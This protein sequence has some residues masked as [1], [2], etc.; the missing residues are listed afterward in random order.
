MVF[1]QMSNGRGALPNNWGLQWMTVDYR[2]LQGM[3]VV[4][5]GM[6]TNDLVEMEKCV[7]YDVF[8][9]VTR[10]F[11]DILVTLYY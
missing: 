6:T 11:S 10:Y 4:L 2:A 7:S 3:T 8:L 5:Q 9:C 1:K